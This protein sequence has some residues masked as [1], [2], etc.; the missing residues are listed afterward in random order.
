MAGSS[1]R[2]KRAKR[3]GRPRR[4]GLNP[5][6]QAPIVS[7][8]SPA[9]LPPQGGDST[10]LSSLPTSRTPWLAPEHLPG[11]PTRPSWKLPE[12][13]PA[14]AKAFAIIALRA[15]GEDD[16][17][18]AGQ[19]GISPKSISSILYKAGKNGWLDQDATLYDPK[20]RF[21]YQI[22]HKVVRNIE[23]ALDDSDMDRRTTVA[24]KMAEYTLPK[25]A[26]VGVGPQLPSALIA[27]RIEQV[28]TGPVREGT[29]F[30][31]PAFVE[32][33]TLASE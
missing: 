6:V 27:I 22:G 7:G 10:A 30:G 18:I 28:D 23:Q 21:E 33:E 20:D 5:A 25:R 31:V 14:K 13:S 16:G 29:V 9:S 1:S 15:A 3:V 12:D 17:A 19:L 32:G 11:A 8:A 4:E 26:E 2:K 24:L